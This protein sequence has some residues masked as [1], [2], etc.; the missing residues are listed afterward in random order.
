MKN[1]ANDPEALVLHL[2]GLPGHR[3]EVLDL[4]P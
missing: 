2:H 3:S 4:A 1:G